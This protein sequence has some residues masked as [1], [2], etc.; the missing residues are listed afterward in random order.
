MEPLYGVGIEQLSL[1]MNQLPDL[2]ALLNFPGLIYLNLNDCGGQDLS[3]LGQ[4]T[5][6]QSL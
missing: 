4:L 2:S 3:L 6:L 5:D 1:D